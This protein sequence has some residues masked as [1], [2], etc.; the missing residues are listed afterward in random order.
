MAAAREASSL[1]HQFVFGGNPG[2]VVGVSNHVPAHLAKGVEAERLKFCEEPSFDATPFL[3]AELRDIFVNPLDHAASPEEGLQ[4]PRVNVRCSAKERLRLLEKLDSS[5]RLRFMRPSEVRMRFRNGLFAVPK[6]GTRD[7]MVLDARPPNMLEDAASPWINTLASVSQLEH[8]FLEE[9]QE[10][11]LFAEDLREFYH[12]FII[13]EQRTRR[14]A[15][16]CEVTPEQVAHFRCFDESLRGE[17]TL[18]PCLSTMAMGDCHA[19]TMGQVSHLAVLLRTGAVRLDDFIMLHS[20]PSRRQWLAGLMIDDLVLLERRVRSTIHAD[21]PESRPPTTCEKIIEEVRKKYEEVGLPRH[22]GKAV[23]N[24]VEGTFWGVQFDGLRGEVR[25]SY[26]RSMPL[27]FILQRIA[28]LGVSTVGLLE[29]IAGSLVAVFQT[30]RRFMSILEEIHVAQRGRLRKD[31]VSLS[32]E[33]REELL[34]AAA[35]V[36]LTSI[37]FRLRASPHLVASDA[38]D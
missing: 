14:N 12:A 4:P 6:D 13:S 32:V 24:S 16:A 17:T 18:V 8:V 7:R 25:P 26:K 3:S 35:L 19:V 5:G 29:V 36:P 22:P 34:V 15:L 9:D 27:V 33:L 38:F 30:K 10:M 21:D 11:R 20:R 31:I 2:E 28:D 23:H 1:A 37:D